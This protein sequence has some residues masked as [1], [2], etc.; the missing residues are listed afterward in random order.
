MWNKGKELYLKYR[1]QINY[2]IVGGLTTAVSLA[3]YWLSVNTVLDPKQPLQLQAA[4][5][6]SWICAVA[7]AYFTNR[8]FVFRS[9]EQNRLK[10]AGKFVLSRLTTLGMEMIIMGLGVSVL[11]LPDKAVKLVAQFIIIIANYVLSKLLVFQK[12]VGNGE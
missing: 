10:E 1:E 7:F 2:L 6:I 5:V 8:R 3:T 11:G 12:K 4:N 9:R